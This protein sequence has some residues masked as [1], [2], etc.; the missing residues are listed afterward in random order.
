M[1]EFKKKYMKNII[2]MILGLELIADF[3]LKLRFS[4]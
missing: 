3:F 1:I 4:F 2:I